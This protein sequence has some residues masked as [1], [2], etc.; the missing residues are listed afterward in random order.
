M[1]TSL[2]FVLVFILGSCFAQ[3]QSTSKSYYWVKLKDKKG[4]PFQITK[5]EQ[6]LSQ[7]AIDRR[8][9]QHIAIDES[10]L[11]VS[12]V[13]LDSLKKRGLEIFHTSRWLNG[14]T[15]RVA[16]T[17]LMRTIAKLPFVTSMQYTRP[18]NSVKSAVNKFRSEETTDIDPANYSTAI[19]Q[20]TQLNGQYLHNKGFRGKGVQI[21]VLDAGF[22]HVNQIAAF[23]SLR[24]SG[25]ILSTHDLVNPYS[26]FYESHTHGMSVLSCMGAN[27]PGKLIG[28]APDA[29]FHLIRTE[30][31]GSEYLV[32]EDH[33]VVGAELADSLGADIIN[34]SLGYS[35]FDDPKMNHTLK[36]LDGKTT[37]A[38]QAANMAFAKG[39]LVFNSAGNEGGT[40]WKK[41]TVPSD[42]ENVLS[43]AA[44]DKYG[45]RANFSSVGPAY[46]GAV[47][48]NVAALGGSTYLVT[49]NGVIWYASGTSFSSPVL[50][51]MGACLLQSNP[52]A[53][54]KQLKMAIE[55]SAHQ[56]SKP[57][58]LLGY[59]IPDFGKA[60]QYLKTNFSPNLTE[61]NTWLIT[62]N[63]FS[64]FLSVQNTGANDL[65]NIVVKI[66]NLQG[67]LLLNEEYQNS[68][69]FILKNLSHL[70]NGFLIATINSGG[71]EERIKLIKTAR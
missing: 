30:E 13:Y 15:V 44:V 21:A 24:L 70:P 31:D 25:R 50:A 40:A 68:R 41:I 1:I 58:S 19:T 61:K 62:P 53:N 47:K 49:G 52:Y 36:D 67:S 22:W 57:D 26:N 42:G 14:A 23:D 28:T 33:W 35:T 63:P 11:P 71:K 9:R 29:S 54:A 12:P 7:R 16:D 34:S 8:A 39:I 60:D 6:F 48:P 64:T 17:S 43:V 65:K 10:D 37:R 55:Q 38:T 66:Y 3:A 20:L 5:P 27:L 46:G 2:V 69:S 32:E 51:G 18:A 59:G 45:T 4:T 56:Y